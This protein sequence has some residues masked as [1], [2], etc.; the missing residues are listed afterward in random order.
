MNKELIILIAFLLFHS[1]MTFADA[2][3]RPVKKLIQM[4]KKVEY[5]RHDSLAGGSISV[6][7]SRG[8]V[9]IK[10]YLILEPIDDKK[11]IRISIPEAKIHFIPSR[12]IEHWGAWDTALGASKEGKTAIKKKPQPI[13]GARTSLQ[14]KD[15]FQNLFTRLF[16]EDSVLMECIKSITFKNAMMSID[17]AGAPIIQVSRVSGEIIKKD[18]MP[19][20]IILTAGYLKYYRFRV[21]RFSAEIEMCGPVWK[22]KSLDAFWCDG[23]LHASADLNMPVRKI[24]TAQA[25]ITNVNIAKA[26]ALKKYHDGIVKGRIS[27]VIAIQD[28]PLKFEKMN[29]MVQVNI[30]G[31]RATGLPLISQI[32]ELTRRVGIGSLFFSKVEGS[33]VLSAGKIKTT[34]LIATGKALT[35]SSNGTINL[36]S[37]YYYFQVKGKIPASYQAHSSAV[38]WN[39]LTPQSNGDRVFICKMYGTEMNPVVEFDKKLAKRA[40]QSFFGEVGRR[41]RGLFTTEK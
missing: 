9:S 40:V 4:K 25:T 18:T 41:I 37:G 17:S 21:T 3:L 34:D 33:F 22:C 2:S 27:A 10:K 31:L 35:V 38:V 13:S 1:N 24:I 36:K 28:S 11:I 12:L 16:L 19:T 8:I 23:K 32:S 15:M 39:T 29:G 26:Y 6:T 14:K 30:T 5:L 20:R 7:P